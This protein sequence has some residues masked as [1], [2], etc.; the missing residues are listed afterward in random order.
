MDWGA[1]EQFTPAWHLCVAAFEENVQKVGELLA[2]GVNPNE[3]APPLM[4]ALNSS[5]YRGNLEILEILLAAGADPDSDNGIS[6]VLFYLVRSPRWE[7]NW[8][9]ALAAKKD[10]LAAAKKLIGAGANVH[11]TDGA[12]TDT[13]CWSLF[14]TALTFGRRPLLP[15]LLRAGAAL[16]TTN[17][18]RREH[19]PAFK[20]C[21]VLVDKVWKAKGFDEYAK[22]HARLIASVVSKCFAPGA[23]PQEIYAVVATFVTPRGGY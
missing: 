5:C 11:R 16:V 21:W 9:N 4:S 8:P 10:L 23:L 7:I 14:A 19:T 12:M 6:P 20:S 1:G 17:V 18:E 3:G 22:H 2:S 15:L 13:P